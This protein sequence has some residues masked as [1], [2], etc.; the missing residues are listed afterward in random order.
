MKDE[1]ANPIN[2]GLPNYDPKRFDDEADDFLPI[3]FERTSGGRY[4]VLVPNEW[5]SKQGTE[6]EQQ[7]KRADFL[8][9]VAGDQI[10]RAK[11][12]TR[13]RRESMA[14]LLTSAAAWRI[15][16]NVD[17]IFCAKF[18][19]QSERKAVRI[20]IDDDLVVSSKEEAD[21]LVSSIVNQRVVKRIMSELTDQI[22]SN[23]DL[24]FAIW[25]HVFF[26]VVVAIDENHGPLEN[27]EDNQ[28]DSLFLQYYH[29]GPVL[30]RANRQVGDYY[31]RQ[32]AR[33]YLES[34][35]PSSWPIEELM[36]FLNIEDDDGKPCTVSLTLPPSQLL[37]VAEQSMKVGPLLSEMKCEFEGGKI[38]LKIELEFDAAGV[39][40]KELVALSRMEPPVIAGRGGDWRDQAIQELWSN[41]NCKRF[42]D[43]VR[44]LAPK[45]NWIKSN[46]YDPRFST[47]QE[48]VTE[49]RNRTEFQGL[50]GGYKRLTDDLLLRVTDTSLSTADREPVALAC[51][52]AARELDIMDIYQ[53]CGRPE[54]AA[55]TLK[56]YYKRGLRSE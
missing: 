50:F 17:H 1:Q 14:P 51:V 35:N 11:I 54:P 3:T 42:A 10:D 41:S 53:N 2:P 4:V 31:G 55:S 36:R 16:V 43:L 30:H 5:L 9:R 25:N 40:L 22:A 44:E 15:F 39:E 13:E 52:H 8:Y 46:D 32:I 20:S 48:W 7:I 12:D 38:K 18:E 27:L 6:R 34:I 45:W 21:E 26:L 56:G 33:E 29:S 47:Q 37:R 23:M 49:V 28:F 19:A 24:I